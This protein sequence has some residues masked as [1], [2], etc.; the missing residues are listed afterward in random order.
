MVSFSSIHS[1][2]RL[3][4]TDAFSWHAVVDTRCKSWRR[5]NKACVGARVSVR[6]WRVPACV[7]LGRFAVGPPLG[8]LCWQAR[9]RCVSAD[10]PTPL[11]IHIQCQHSADRDPPRAVSQLRAQLAACR[12]RTHHPQQ[13][14][15]RPPVVPVPKHPLPVQGGRDVDAEDRGRQCGWC[16]SRESTRRGG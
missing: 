1:A 15:R 2:L 7:W 13:A 4:A 9:R 3:T 5:H 8:C 16:H 11:S 12:T 10:F 6:S 14:L